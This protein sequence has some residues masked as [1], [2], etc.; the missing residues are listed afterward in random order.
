[1]RD[2]PVAAKRVAIKEAESTDGL[3]EAAPGALL[4]LDEESLVFA[5]VLGPQLFG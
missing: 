1:M 5:D 3:V 4:F 2:R